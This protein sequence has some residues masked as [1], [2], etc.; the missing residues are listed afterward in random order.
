MK[1]LYHFCLSPGV[2][3]V[4]ARVYARM[5]HFEGVC[6][7]VDFFRYYYYHCAFFRE[8]N[9]SL[10]RVGVMYS[11]SSRLVEVQT[12]PSRGQFFL[13][14]FPPKELFI[15]YACGGNFRLGR[16]FLQSVEHVGSM[17]IEKRSYQLCRRSESR[18]LRN[19]L[20]KV[21]FYQ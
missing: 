13:S 17:S 9:A 7:C 5:Y 12:F 14:A 3:C 2:Q 21:I 10:A 20:W 11:S 8:R 19:Q 1:V 4:R 15:N 16:A 6:V 18:P